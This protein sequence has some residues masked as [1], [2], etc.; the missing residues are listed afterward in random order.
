M[1][2]D[3]DPDHAEVDLRTADVLAVALDVTAEPVT[4]AVELVT[5]GGNRSLYDVTAGQFIQDWQTPKRA[6][7]CCTV[8]MKADDGSTISDNFMLM[9]QP[10]RSCPPVCEPRDRPHRL[11]IGVSRSGYGARHG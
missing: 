3:V 7:S 9:Q 5:T 11:P 8:A 1:V 2:V 6:G 10:R 4:D